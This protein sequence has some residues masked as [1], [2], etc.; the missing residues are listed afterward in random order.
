MVPDRVLIAE[1]IHEDGVTILEAAAAVDVH[2]QLSDAELTTI[3]AGYDA[4]IVRS[5]TRVT[6]SVI[7]AG[8]RLRVI[9]K[10]PPVLEVFEAAGMAELLEPDR[11]A[12]PRM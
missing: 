12:K 4:L 6:S 1:P 8:K 10:H 9:G 2:P 7:A 11:R 3:I 5:R